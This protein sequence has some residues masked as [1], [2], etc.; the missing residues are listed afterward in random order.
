M[1]L[2]LGRC[3][4]LRPSSPGRKFPI[5]CSKGGRR[6]RRVESKLCEAC[7]DASRP[8]REHCHV[9]RP[10]SNTQINPWNYKLLMTGKL[11]SDVDDEPRN[12]LEEHIIPPEVS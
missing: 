3:G 12:E 10:G 11:S 4:V 1:K 7:Q 8:G 5:P 9:D 2:T 6:I